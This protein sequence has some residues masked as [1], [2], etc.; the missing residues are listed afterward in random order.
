MNYDKLIAKDELRGVWMKAMCV[1]L[2]RLAQR[3]QDTNGTDTFKFMTL[4]RIARIP[5][6]FMVMYVCIMVD[7]RP[8]KADPNRVQITIG[9]S[10]IGDPY[11][12]TTRTADLITS[13]VM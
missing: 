9:S 2:G 3:Y 11:K 7:Y 5:R 6:D 1:E 8:Q 12:L 4:E 13:K 10:L